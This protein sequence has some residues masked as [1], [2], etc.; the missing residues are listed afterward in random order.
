MQSSYIAKLREAIQETE[1]CGSRYAG[2]VR[3]TERFQDETAWDGLVEIFDLIDHPKAQ[4]C[5]AW[6]YEE[7]GELRS[8]IV[9]R[10][11]PVD[12][13]QTAVKVAIAAKARQK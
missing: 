13:P 3:V 2:T 6:G 9:L 8:T 5:Y 10:L 7:R 1:N 12:S 11:P 4:V